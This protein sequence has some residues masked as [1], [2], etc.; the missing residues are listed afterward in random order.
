MAA[1]SNVAQ[2]P[3][4]IASFEEPLCDLLD[5]LKALVELSKNNDG[6]LAVVVRQ[7]TASMLKDVRAML[8]A[9]ENAGS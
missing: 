7:M 5:G 6:T 4:S 9:V 8:H 1:D 2:Q 3:T